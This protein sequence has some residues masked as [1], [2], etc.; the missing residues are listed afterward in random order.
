MSHI[1]RT[2]NRYHE[3]FESYRHVISLRSPLTWISLIL[4]ASWIYFALD[5]IIYPESNLFSMD[6]KLTSSLV[7]AFE[8]LALICWKRI[9]DSRNQKIIIKCQAE[10]KTDI[11]DIKELK[12]I[13]F[14]KTL[15]VPQ[16]E[17]LSLAK[18]I[19]EF[20]S[21]SRK[22]SRTIIIDSK[23]IKDLIFTTESKGRL[24]TLF[25]SLFAILTTLSIAGGANINNVLIFYKGQSILE[26]LTLDSLLS[27]FIIF[28]WI[29]L[30]FLL[31]MLKTLFEITFIDKIS[32]EHK[33]Q[34]R[35]RNFIDQILQLH[36]FKK[37]KVS[38]LEV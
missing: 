30:I 15:A 8:V 18:E 3:R 7:I 2:I 31:T 32:L 10:F 13:W 12:R 1:Y 29:A 25:L 14:K 5:L 21:L 36:E 28:T 24:L 11:S 19:D 38:S 20:I 23:A 22:N 9:I 16:H 4:T 34:R 17:Y 6:K 33:S 27:I 26:L 35:A 37:A